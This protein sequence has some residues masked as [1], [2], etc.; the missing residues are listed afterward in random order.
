[1]NILVV[2]D[3]KD[4]LK[5]VSV[6]LR[7]HDYKVF[8]ANSLKEAVSFLKNNKIDLIFADVCL[9]DGIF[10]DIIPE[11]FKIDKNVKIIFTTVHMDYIDKI[12]SL[13]FSYI[14]KPYDVNQVIRKIKS[15]LR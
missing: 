2:E 6:G 10:I 15:I 5:L 8:E 13:K 3:D 7:H 4:L 11:V 12:R 1:M 9:P 14:L